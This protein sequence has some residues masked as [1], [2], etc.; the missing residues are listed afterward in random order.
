MKSVGTADW[1]V[2][3][4]VALIGLALWFMVGW[5]GVLA[6]CGVLAVAAG[7]AEARR[8]RGAPGG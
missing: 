5:A 1:L 4:G 2:L 8:N 7:V 6:W 3:L